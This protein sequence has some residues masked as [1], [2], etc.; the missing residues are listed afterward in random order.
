MKSKQLLSHSFDRRLF[1]PEAW[2]APGSLHVAC[3]VSLGTA[4]ILFTSFCATFASASAH[5]G[6]GP[7]QCSCGDGAWL[8][9]QT[10]ANSARVSI[11]GRNYDLQRGRSSIGHK[12]LSADAALIIDGHS[13]VFVAGQYLDLGACVEAVPVALGDGSAKGP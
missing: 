3:R 9:V 10:N 8:T 11:D 6:T 1:S 7:V 2:F 4:R 12:Y 5:A 13:A